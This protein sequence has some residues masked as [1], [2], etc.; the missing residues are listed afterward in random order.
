MPVQDTATE[1]AAQ[2]GEPSNS[3]SPMRTTTAENTLQLTAY[4]KVDATHAWP[5]WRANL[6]VLVHVVAPQDML[7]RIPIDV[8]AVLDVGYSHGAL[9]P[10]NRMCLLN[11]AMDFVIRKLNSQDRLAIIATPKIGEEET[12]MAMTS[13]GQRKAMSRVKAL[14]ASGDN[15]LVLKAL[16][17]AG[18]IL[19]GRTEE[20][21]KK[22]GFIILISDG[23]DSSICLETLN[24]GYPVHAFGFRDAHNAGQMHHIAKSTSGTYC[25][26]NDEHDQITE[27]YTACI[28][29][30][31]SVVAARTKIYIAYT[32]REATTTFS[33]IKS[34]TFK[35][36]IDNVDRKRGSINVGALQAGAARSF[37]VYMHGVEEKEHDELAKLLSVRVEFY[38]GL[39][40]EEREKAGE[41]VIARKGV[42]G[43]RKVAAEIVRIKAVEIVGGILDR[44]SGNGLTGAA[45][46]ELWEK[47]INL[48]ST[49]YGRE[50]SDACLTARLD[51][52]MEEMVATM[53]Q[54]SGLS[55]MVSWHTR[56]SLQHL[57]LQPEAKAKAKGPPSM[58][59]ASAWGVLDAPVI[60]GGCGRGKR[61][62]EHY[63]EMEMIERR[64]AYW[65]TVLC[66]LPPMHKGGCPGH[67]AM[68]S[69]EVSR[70]SIL[71]AM[72]KDVFLAVAMNTS[73]SKSTECPCCLGAANKRHLD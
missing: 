66:G 48:K 41:V 71:Q 62:R 21:K 15:K 1:N 57:P 2:L 69:Q 36:L 65:S 24:P 45:A 29:S 7:D 46:D 30:I 14:A 64:M 3:Q 73:G 10:A 44:Y 34:G 16:T 33:D 23:E 59:D 19:E 20:E 40:A 43:S 56:Q 13:D 4:A 38:A 11:R 9:A 60:A 35:S 39:R 27:A 32:G 58:P 5:E 72:Y 68:L 55:Y 31:A 51:A 18:A 26:L 47:W 17:K 53:R 8:V 6:P 28:V 42:D 54:G 49:E 22:E 50:A 37:I 63:T 12:L 52:E 25:V 61:K 67:V 70:K